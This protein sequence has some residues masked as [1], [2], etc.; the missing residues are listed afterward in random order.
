M[1]MVITKSSV[2]Y[3]FLFFFFLPSH[4]PLRAQRLN[5]RN[6]EGVYVQ[7]GKKLSKLK[8]NQ[9]Q[10]KTSK[11]RKVASL[12]VPAIDEKKIVILPGVRA[13]PR[14]SS[15][16]PVF[17]IHFSDA[18]RFQ[19]ALVRLKPKDKYREISEVLISPLRRDVEKK[20]D[21]VFSHVR[22]LSS[23][24]YKLTPAEPLSPGEYA[25]ARLPRVDPFDTKHVAVE[26]DVWDFGIDIRKLKSGVRRHSSR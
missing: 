17:Y 4:D 14:L 9:A 6:Q 13:R 7:D 3:I 5:F 11:K 21:S 25:L 20:S 8:L 19:F 26:L 15:T 1:F 16:K 12:L 18:D 22:G 2:V 10:I 24:I 23:K